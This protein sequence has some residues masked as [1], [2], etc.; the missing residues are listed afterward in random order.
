VAC[1]V[2]LFDMLTTSRK[3]SLAVEK[4]RICF[5]INHQMI[6]WSTSRKKVLDLVLCRPGS[7]EARPDG[8]T[9]KELASDY[10]VILTPQER[11]VLQRL[12]PLRRGPVGPVYVALEAKACMTEHAKARPRLY[13]EL[14]SSHLTIHGDSEKAVAVAF[15]MVNAAT[16]F[17]SPGRAKSDGAIELTQ[18]VQPAAA[19]CVVDKL[20]EI[21]RSQA[22]GTRGFDALGIV[23][24]DLRNDGSPVAVVTRA[25]APKAGDA[26]HYDMMIQR[27]VHAFE[28]RF[29]DLANG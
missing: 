29:G 28:E 18:H 25:P 4:G 23:V 10:G 16:H 9:F 26:F 24:V 17:V 13:D 6:D 21:P 15:C 3:L 27:A 7:S 1:W 11:A 5:G 20:Q 8:V 2:T 22:V 19:Q 14:N 12:P